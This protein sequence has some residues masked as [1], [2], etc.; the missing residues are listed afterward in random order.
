MFCSAKRVARAISSGRLQG[1]V[2]QKD[3]LIDAL[4]KA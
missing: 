2:K 3:S 4:S 1:T